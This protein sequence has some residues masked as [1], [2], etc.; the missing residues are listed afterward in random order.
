MA[1]ESMTFQAPIQMFLGTFAALLLLSSLI[2]VNGQ[3]TAAWAV[4]DWTSGAHATFYG[5]QDA[6]GTM[7]K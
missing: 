4:T 1:A 5:G 3:D 6:S 2:L 7:G